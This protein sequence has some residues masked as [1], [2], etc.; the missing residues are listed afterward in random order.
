MPWKEQDLMSLKREFV[1]ELLKNNISVTELC[2]RYQISRK[3]AYK[4]LNRYQE[5][6]IEG[7]QEKNR[8]PLNSPT[9][10]KK[11]IEDEIIKIREEHPA[12]GGRKIKA[13]L[14]RKGFEE[15]P[16]ASAIS[17]ILKKNGYILD[18]KTK[19]RQK[20]VRFEHEAPN[21]LWQMDFKGYFEFEKGR[22]YPL[23]ILDDHSRYSIGL[24]ACANERGVIVKDHMI[25]IFKCYGL[26]YRI[27]V[28]NGNPWGSLFECA[29]YTTFSVWLIKVGVKISYSR[30]GHPET[31]GKDERFHRTLKEELIK[32][33]YFKNFLHIQREFD[34]WREVYNYERP[35]EA[36]GMKVPADRYRT[37]YRKYED[38]VS[39]EYAGDYQKRM[40]DCRGRIH[41]EGRQVFIGMPFAKEVIGIRG[42]EQSC[43]VDIY[44]L[45]Q[46]LGK[47]DLSQVPKKSM[48]NL[49][50]KR[51]SEL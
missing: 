43:A 29:R 18:L 34:N 17:K 7:L 23:T 51:I 30:P 4:W 11:T 22:C 37:S 6:G 35:H 40:V 39:Y 49:Y 33:S 21:H 19:Q 38:Q 16:A 41:L 32:P 3:T 12:W 8:R 28:D 14:E 9:K 2:N 45:H 15:V 31:N 1:V 26:P 50:S 46:K 36:I 42:T 24:K 47:L 20:H 27:N 13:I 44:F 48:V 5:K 10:T 25:E